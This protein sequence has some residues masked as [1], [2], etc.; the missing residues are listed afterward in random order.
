MLLPCG[1]PGRTCDKVAGLAEPFVRQ[2]SERLE[3]L[4]RLRAG[5]AGHELVSAAHA[6]RA[7]RGQ[8]ARVRRP[9]AGGRDGQRDLGVEPGQRADQERRGPRVQPEAVAD[10]H[11]RRRLR[12]ARRGRA[13][14][15]VRRL[16]FA[17]LSGLAREAVARGRGHAGEGFAEPGRDGRGHGALDERRGREQYAVAPLVAEQVQGQLGREDG[18]AEVHQ[19][20]HAVV[21]PDVLDRREHPGGVGAQGAGVVQPAGGADAHLRAGHLGGQLRDALGELRA[22]AD[23]DE[24]DH[25]YAGSASPAGAAAPAGPAAAPASAS[26]AVSSSSQELVAPGSWCPALRSPR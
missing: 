14:R 1:V 8:A 3:R 6:Q 12:L 11:A 17:K 5:R 19:D 24:A 4:R 13:R 10:G 23:D 2:A 22:V 18:A 26:A 25:C 21:R 15:G 9:L 20:Q 16:A 7:D